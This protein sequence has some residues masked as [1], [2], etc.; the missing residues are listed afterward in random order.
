AEVVASST[1]VGDRVVV[2][3]EGIRLADDAIVVGLDDG[4]TIVAVPED[5]AATVAA[6]ASSTAGVALL[7]RP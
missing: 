7:L 6:A 4:V 5:D 3:A 1:A 2:A